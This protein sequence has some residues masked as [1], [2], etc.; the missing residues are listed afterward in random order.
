MIM[1]DKKSEQQSSFAKSV[2]RKD[3]VIDGINMSGIIDLLE[4]EHDCHC[5]TNAEVVGVSG[6]THSFALVAKKGFETISVGLVQHKTSILDSFVAEEELSE[7]LL[8][9]TIKLGV[10][11][12]DCGSNLVL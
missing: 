10:K 7:Q 12:M 9:E 1:N 5:F 8:V 3:T 4:G 2:M 6:V 11:S